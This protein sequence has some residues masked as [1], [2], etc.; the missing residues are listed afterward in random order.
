MGRV[1]NPET[2]GKERTQLSKAL[3]LTLRELSQKS[4]VDA[5]TRDMAAYI[6]LCLHE[7]NETVEGS[8]TAWEKRGYW[9]KADKFRMEWL[10]TQNYALQLRQAVL[11]NDWGEVPM[12][13]A[14][15]GQKLATV[16]L[17][18]RNN[19]GKIWLGALEKLK[20]MPS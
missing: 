16:K 2:A 5:E 11:R 6:A 19:L 14:R 15:V 17:P 12:M 9:V 3:L 13:L 18:Q 4:E 10:W 8:V 7:M 20:S 1:I